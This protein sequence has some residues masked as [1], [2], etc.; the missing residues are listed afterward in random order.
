MKANRTTAA[1]AKIARNLSRFIYG[2]VIEICNWRIEEGEEDAQS[3]IK[4]IEK[5]YNVTA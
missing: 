4:A 5:K 1:T 2:R 3:W